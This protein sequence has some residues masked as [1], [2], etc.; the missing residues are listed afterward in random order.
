[1]QN[2]AVNGSQGAGVPVGTMVAVGS[3]VSVGGGRV[4]V[5]VGGRMIGVDVASGVGAGWGAV[6]EAR[7]INKIRGN[8]FFITDKKYIR[9]SVFS[10][11]YATMIL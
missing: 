5:S 11:R 4:A 8:S 9:D 2:S 10:S 3:G 1:M 6:Q 7:N